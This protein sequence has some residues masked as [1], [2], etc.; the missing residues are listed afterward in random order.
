MWQSRTTVPGSLQCQSAMQGHARLPARLPPVL[1]VGPHMELLTP[2]VPFPRA[3]RVL[4]SVFPSAAYLCGCCE[5]LRSSYSF[6]NPFIFLARHE[7]AEPELWNEPSHLQWVESGA[8]PRQWEREFRFSLQPSTGTVSAA[9]SD[10][11]LGHFWK[12]VLNPPSLHWELW[13]L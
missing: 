4:L 3:I 7:K 13:Q 2:G 1:L 6:T 12:E 8:D 11:S 10:T 9:H 5:M